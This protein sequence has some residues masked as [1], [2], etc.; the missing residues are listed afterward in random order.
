MKTLTYHDALNHVLALA[1][2]GVIVI[3]VN[4]PVVT[5]LAMLAVSFSLARVIPN[6]NWHR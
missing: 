6:A 3:L 1:A 4:N 2:T 5:L